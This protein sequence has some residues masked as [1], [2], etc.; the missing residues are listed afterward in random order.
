[1]TA[2][3][4]R[5]MAHKTSTSFLDMLKIDEPPLLPYSSYTGRIVPV[6][7][8]VPRSVHRTGPKFAHNPCNLPLTVVSNLIRLLWRCIVNQLYA[9]ATL[10]LDVSCGVF[11]ISS[12]FFFFFKLCRCT[13]RYEDDSSSSSL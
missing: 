10:F 2:C 1:M 4:C 9:S 8:V 6:V 5:F 7:L 12:F 3:C 11:S 13:N